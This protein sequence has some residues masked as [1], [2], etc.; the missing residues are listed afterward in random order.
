MWTINNH[1]ILPELMEAFTPAAMAQRRK[2]QQ[3]VVELLQAFPHERTAPK[4]EQL[5]VEL[6]QGSTKG[7]K[8][9]LRSTPPIT[10][11]Q[12]ESSKSNSPKLRSLSSHMSMLK[13]ISHSNQS[14]YHS[15]EYNKSAYALMMEGDRIWEKKLRR[16]GR[17]SALIRVTPENKDLLVGHTT[18][19]DYSKMTRIWKYY[20]WKIYGAWTSVSHLSMSSYPG[21]VSSTDNFF[22]L[23]NGL[24]VMDTTLEILNTKLYDRVAEFPANPHIPAFAHIMMVNRMVKNLV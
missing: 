6:S 19:D 11:P 17:C 22:M 20:N 8:R 5:K 15:E 10:P 1:G 4:R 2:Y 21:C 23:D 12:N 7:K 13:G 24:V 18:W 3:T 14:A 9:N 16:G